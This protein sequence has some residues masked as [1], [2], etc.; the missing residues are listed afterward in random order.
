VNDRLFL[1]GK[2]L[3]DSYAVGFKYTVKILAVSA[4]TIKTQTYISIEFLT[5]HIAKN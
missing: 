4:A 2:T 1:S 3:D 5:C